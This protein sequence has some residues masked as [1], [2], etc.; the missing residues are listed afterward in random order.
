VQE[1]VI[2][3]I[4]NQE[5]GKNGGIFCAKVYVPAVIPYTYD[6]LWLYHYLERTI[7]TP[8]DSFQRGYCWYIIEPDAK[9]FTYRITTWKLKNIPANA[10]TKPEETRI[11]NGIEISKYYLE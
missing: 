2:N 3:E 9:E 8:R 11:I 5:K 1:T 4:V 10:K 6:Y 7:E